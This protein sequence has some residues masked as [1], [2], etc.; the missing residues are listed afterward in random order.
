MSQ[1]RAPYN[2][3]P[4]YHK[5]IWRYPNESV[6]PHHDV[7][8]PELLSGE[9]Q[10]TMTAQTPVF[11]SNGK[12]GKEAEFVKDAQGRYCIPGSTL[13]GLIRENMQILGLGLVRAGEDLEDYRLL[14]RDMTSATGS[15]AESRKKHYI[16][17]LDIT[18]KTGA[19]GKRY[20]VAKAVR[21]GYLH[22]KN[23]KYFIVPTELEVLSINRK[24]PI[25]APWAKKY[26]FSQ[27]VWYR[28][29]GNK[30][31]HLRANRADGFRQ[32]M[33]LSPG[34]MWKQNRLYLFP[35]EASSVDAVEL[36]E[37]EVLS[38]QEDF[39]MKYT[40]LR[41]TDKENPMDPDFWK[42][43][44]EGQGKPVFY[45]RYNGFTSFGM[46]QFLRVGY[47]H[48]LG[49]GLP[50]KH[51]E[52]RDSLAL[53]YP[54]SI[55]GFA[56]KERSYRSRVS[57]GNLT[58]VG[59]P[60]AMEPISL[61]LG[62]PKPSFFPGYVREGQDYN[63]DGFQLNGYKQYWIKNV[64]QPNAGQNSNVASTLRP[65]P[66][67]TQFTGV[68][69][70]RNLHEDELGLLLWCLRLDEGCFQTIGMGKPYG[71]GR[72]KVT[73]DA[74]HQVDTACLYSSLTAGLKEQ[75][76]TWEQVESFIRAYDR[77][78]YKQ[79]NTEPRQGKNATLRT[80]PPIEDFLY[81]KKT[82]RTDVHSAPY[83]TLKE[84]QNVQKPLETVSSIRQAA[85]PVPNEP[86]DLASLIALKNKQSAVSAAPKTKKKGF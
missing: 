58:A 22:C 73:I 7:L 16:G 56:E 21:G 86:T 64:R 81:M 37:K 42:L 55:L 5:I 72:M 1:V 65:L 63:K 44:E 14:Y 47:E 82:I 33:L 60:R 49:E 34:R 26:A 85:V 10:V 3:V 6:L 13:R 30:V 35:A 38:Y 52:A 45:V 62:E 15:R 27:T 84:H 17:A 71:Y 9:I 76:Q 80:E 48:S 57:V 41:G 40:G 28:A 46:S 11:V 53:D 79:A 50:K 24:A 70:Y 39:Q 54:H 19:S 78:A 12:K 77:Y 61:L 31:T 68:I 4:F 59:S 29:A 25:A 36:G 8:N 69:R 23:K 18:Q 32:G 74:L 67:G 75:G 2:F 20:S 83:M 66:V 51:R 43:P